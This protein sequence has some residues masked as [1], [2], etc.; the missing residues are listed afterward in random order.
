MTRREDGKETRRRL[1][2]AACEVFAQH[3]YRQTRVA[4][5]CHRAGANVAS[6]N[7]YF[8]D[9]KSL[10]KEAWRHTLQHFN[11]SIFS[12]SDADSDQE[13]LRAH[14][15]TLIR[16]FA[17]DGDLGRFSRLYLME[18]VHPTGLIQDAWHDT[19]EPNR[20]KLHLIIRGIL[21]ADADDL[22]VRF[23]ELSIVNQCRMFVTVKRDDLEYML[24]APLSPELIERL[25]GHIADFSL[26]GIRA[27]GREP[28]R[29]G[30]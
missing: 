25:A 28:G 22:D 3:G 4:D 5:I 27:L 10:Y 17:A 30:Q 2:R 23:C 14:I 9:K 11:E 24:G 8:R 15:R 20:R 16:N 7:Y 18:M 26:A 12:K 1:L 19:I 6:V 13:R 21:G 29:A